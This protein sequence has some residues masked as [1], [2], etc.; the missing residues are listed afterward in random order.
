M[1]RDWEQFKE[2]MLQ[3]NHICPMCFSDETIHYVERLVMYDKDGDVVGHKDWGCEYDGWKC[4]E[5]G[6]ERF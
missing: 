1:F 2:I 4:D 3:I 6:W 5:C